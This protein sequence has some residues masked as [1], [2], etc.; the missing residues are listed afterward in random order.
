MINKDRISCILKSSPCNSLSTQHTTDNSILTSTRN[1]EENLKFLISNSRRRA[2]LP[3][4]H[5]LKNFQ[6]L[7]TMN[8]K[9]ETNTREQ[10]LISKD[11]RSQSR[12][13]NPSQVDVDNT[14]NSS[15]TKNSNNLT[16]MIPNFQVENGSIDNANQQNRASKDND[17]IDDSKN[18]ESYKKINPSARLIKHSEEVPEVDAQLQP[19]QDTNDDETE[20]KFNQL[21]IGRNFRF[22][23]ILVVVEGYAKR[24]Y[25][26]NRKEI[27]SFDDFYEFLVPE[28]EPSDSASYK[29][30]PRQ[31]ATNNS[32]DSIPTYQTNFANES[33]PIVSN[34]SNTIKSTIMV[35]L[36]TID[37]IGERPVINST[38]VSDSFSTPI[39]DQTQNDLRK[40]IAGNLIK[41]P[42]S[43]KGGKD[44]VKKWIEEIEHLLDVA[45]IT[46]ATRLNLISYSLRGD[47]LEWFK[48]NRLLFSSRNIFVS[49]L[50]R[51]FTSS[52]HEELAFKKLESYSQGEHQS[53]RSFFNEVLK[54]CKD[55]DSTMSEA[56]K[57]KNLLN[58]TKPSI[59][60]EVL[61]QQQSIPSLISTSI[62]P[63]NQSFGK[64]WNNFSPHYSRNFDN[65]YRAPNI[66]STYSN[67]N[68]SSFLYSQSTQNKSR[69]TNNFSRYPQQET[70]FNSTNHTHKPYQ[71]P[72]PNY[73]S[74]NYSRER[75]ANTISLPQTTTTAIPLNES[76]PSAICSQC[77]QS[78]HEAAACSNF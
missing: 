70:S 54:L 10:A 22:E 38:I 48:N 26:K 37:G 19:E 61:V 73:S 55:A 18:D 28:F 17:A 58:K 2:I 15:P 62:P 13:K 64:T 56:T 20:N 49:E 51:A 24:K 45:H 57:L 47:A 67:P 52:F 75:T 5:R 29:S 7:F 63:V 21:R 31:T 53:I 77:N 72:R 25:I 44:D 46:D 66:R 69:P 4:P 43:F 23:A 50:I 40:A 16:D 34:N 27:G 59:Q 71:Q 1:P 74:N 76:Y 42:K 36:D 8:N 41:N 12:D 9:K 35:N 32:C 60:F 6:N 68:S 39:S 3:T 78:G 33:N 30:K 14:D 11:T 65:N